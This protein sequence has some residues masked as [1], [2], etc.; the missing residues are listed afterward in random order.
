M[1]RYAVLFN[2]KDIF[3]EIPEDKFREGLVEFGSEDA[4]VAFDKL[5]KELEK[6]ARNR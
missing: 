2:D 6:A 1:L 5:H 4:G 3:V